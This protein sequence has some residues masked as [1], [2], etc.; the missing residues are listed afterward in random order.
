LRKRENKTFCLVILGKLLLENAIEHFGQGVVG[1]G[2][3][4]IDYVSVEPL[5]RFLVGSGR[6]TNASADREAHN[7]APEPKFPPLL[8]A[9]S[10]R[11]HRRCGGEAS[12]RVGPKQ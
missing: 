1:F 8:L 5:S 12:G 10:R 11:R 9:D 4:Q 2:R 7:A 3:R 6:A